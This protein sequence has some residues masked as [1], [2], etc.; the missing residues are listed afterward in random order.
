ME[1]LKIILSTLPILLPFIFL[2][3]LKWGAKKGMFVSSVIFIVLSYF[4]WGMDT[5]IIL[6]S[7]IQG[8]HKAVT[9]LFILFGA[10][11][12]L[13]IL[14]YTGS[15]EIIKK[16]F[17]NISDDM[18]VQA[19]IIGVLFVALIEGSAGFGTPAVVAAPLLMSLGFTPISAVVV[20]LIGDSVP[21]SF[22]AI[23][24]PILVGLGNI[25]GSGIDFFNKISFYVTRVDTLMMLILPTIIVIVLTLN[26][27]KKRS[28]KSSLEV[29]PWT[30]FIGGCYAIIAVTCALL[31]GAEFVSILTPTIV[32]GIAT[33]TAKNKI[34]L[35]KNSTWIIENDNKLNS[36]K[37]DDIEEIEF[38][39]KN[40][41]LAWIPYLLVV[42]LLIATRIIKPLKTFVLTTIDFSVKNIMGMGINSSWQ[43][44]YSPGAILLIAGLI[45]L[46]INSSKFKTDILKKSFNDTIFSVKNAAI[47][48]VFT[49]ALVQTFVNSANSAVGESMPSFFANV[50]ANIFEQNWVFI[51]PFLGIL[52]SFV[53][54][55]AT[56]STLTFSSIQYQVSQTIGINTYVIL[57]MQVIGG[58][59]GN[60]ICVHNVV[61]AAAVVGLVDKEGEIIKKTLSPAI[62]YGI[63]TCISGYFLINFIL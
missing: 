34:L 1:S 11:M 22:G 6:A 3:L 54:G 8:T 49:L 50:L 27:G 2:V 61:A 19:V 17:Q 40:L 51:S 30:L 14:T 32:L 43:V 36:I 41:F 58:A 20:A 44:L 10:I 55:S 33:V 38:T 9:I 37:N 52:G 47:V 57:A 5:N 23:G 18:R 63:A 35:P 60:M 15:M 28:I 7:I 12:L 62:L 29:L 42:A 56:V 13:K 48:L 53:T 31:L 26:F 4:I 45:A 16:G 39:T 59:A 25:P 46:A 24:T 21:V